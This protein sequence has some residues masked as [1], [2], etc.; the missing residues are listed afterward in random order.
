MKWK[1]SSAAFATDVPLTDT[2]VAFGSLYIAFKK[3]KK[4]DLISGS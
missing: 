4:K 1:T 3:S 2:K